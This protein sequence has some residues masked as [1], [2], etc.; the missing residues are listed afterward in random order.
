MGELFVIFLED[1]V[2]DMRCVR[3]MESNLCYREQF[4]PKIETS[5]VI[6][7]NL[8]KVKFLILNITGFRNT[9]FQSFFFRTF[10]F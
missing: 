6:F 5:I 9:V 3:G 2:F 10:P 1:S 8:S 7:L 4:H